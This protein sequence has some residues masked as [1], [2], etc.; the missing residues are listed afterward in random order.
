[1][2]VIWPHAHSIES[3]ALCGELQKILDAD[4]MHLVNHHA[5]VNVDRFAMETTQSKELGPP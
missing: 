2:W 1:M 3:S 4:Q 5:C